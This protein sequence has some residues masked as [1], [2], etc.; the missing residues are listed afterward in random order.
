MKNYLLTVK[1]ILVVSSLIFLVAG[2]EKSL[3]R[4]VDGQPGF[5]VRSDFSAPLNAD[6]G[7]AGALNENVTVEADQPFRIR[8]EVEHSAQMAESQQ[9]R[10][11][12]RRN[13]GDWLPIEAHDFPHPQREMDVD[14]SLLTDGDQS[15]GCM[16]ATGSPSNMI[17]VAEQHDQMLRI[18]AGD[19]TFSGFFPAPWEVTELA[20]Q[21]RLPAQSCNGIAFVVGYVDPDNYCRVSLNPT[22]QTLNISQIIDGDEETCGETHAV[23]P[24]GA[25]L[26]I[27]IEI[28]R[29]AI[30]VSFQ[31]GAVELEAV[32]RRPIVLSGPGFQ[33]PLQTQLDFQS[34]ALVGEA[35]TPRVSIVACSAYEQGTATEGLLTGSRQPFQAGVGISL[36]EQTRQW[37]GENAHTEYEWPLVIRRYA[38]GAVTNDS[39][40]TFEF[41]LV[42]ADGVVQTLSHNPVVRL[43]IPPGHVGGTFIEN[44]GRIGPWQA[45]NGDLY[46]MM[47]PA[48]TDNV[49]MMMK[50]TDNGRTWQEVDG[51]HRP[52]TDDLESVDSRLVGDTIHILHQV[53]RS[54][55]YHAFRTSDHPSQPDSWAICDEVAG[56][57]TAIAQTASM[58]VRSDGTIVAFYLGQEKI[59][60]STRKKNGTWSAMRTIDGGRRPNQAGPQAVLGNDDVIHLAY[61]GID[62]TIWYRRLLANGTLTPRQAIATGAGTTRAEYG[63]VLP[64]IYNA[65]KDEVVIIYRLASDLLWERR[66]TSTG[67]VSDATLVT[68][69]KVVTDAVDSQQAGADAVLD[70]D[71][72]HVLFIDAK[73][74]SILSTN[75]SDGWQPSTIQVGNILGSWVRGTLYTRKDGVRVYGYVYDAGSDG[76]AGMNR[77]G[78]LVLTEDVAN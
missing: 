76:G 18:N 31:D 27:E 65:D 42:N 29:N 30:E 10:L 17:V 70:G 19:E 9:Y 43:A 44:P 8:V 5:R 23:V 40:D 53:T 63:A 46:F 78:E 11:E 66:V 34:I 3:E 2:C 36:A 75:D 64:L 57:A 49:F 74:R 14:F 28:A 72:V 69:M 7:W 1:Q 24:V 4:Q 45:G 6:H 62:G 47:E 59:H 39:D 16:V 77:F 22:A 56:T 68:D 52:Q 58:V 61:Y 21:F 55:R 12:Y 54:A 67:V 73:S 41:R 33:V 32:L 13:N 25:W 26:E 15:S 38:D 71:T 60:F 35:K 48:E 37:E 50:S 51:E 20:A